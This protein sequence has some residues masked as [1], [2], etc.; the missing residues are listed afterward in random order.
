MKTITLKTDDSFFEKVNELAKQLHITKSELIRRSI[1]EYESLMKRSAMK[2]Q[3]KEASFRVR[4]A[5]KEMSD[6]FEVML[7]DGLENA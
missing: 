5:G 4:D 3:M 6:A 1:A 2:A 7:N